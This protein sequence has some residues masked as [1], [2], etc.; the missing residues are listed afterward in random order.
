MYFWNTEKLIDDLKNNR[1]TEESFKNY[2]ITV[3]L[4]TLL[5]MYAVHLAP[6]INPQSVIVEFV[7]SIGILIT[8]LNALF[9][10]N[11]GKAGKYF[12]NRTVSLA[13]PISI[14]LLVLSI[15]PYVIFIGTFQ[16]LNG[17]F[18][19]P[20]II[21]PRLEWFDTIF[22]LLIQLITYWRLYVALKKVNS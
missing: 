16:Y 12:L 7:M 20:G 22:T 13:L 14:K 10:A 15:I 4:F 1:L 21:D 17:S 5:G 8:G 3:G 11:G 6:R 2:Y 9:A 18:D 19:K